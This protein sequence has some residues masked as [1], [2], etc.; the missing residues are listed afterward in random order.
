MKHDHDHAHVGHEGHAHTPVLVAPAVARADTCGSC[1]GDSASATPVVNEPPLAGLRYR[2]PAMDCASEESEI[3]RAVEGIAGIRSL[4]FRFS[5]RSLRID[6]APE[7]AELAAERIRRTGFEILPWPQ[8]PSPS[9]AAGGDPDHAPGTGIPRLILALGLATG[10]EVLSFMAPDTLLFKFM[11]MAIAGSAI[12]FAGLDVFKKG[13]SALLHGR[14][15]INA[16]MTVAVAGA[17]V[18]GQW[19]EAAM[20]MAL[21]AIAELIEAKAVDRAR[22][23]IS[24]LMAM[25][26]EEASV[27]RPDG[28]W[29]AMPVASVAVGAIARIRPGERVPLD[30]V[31]TEG[32]S[33]IDQAPVTG[34]GLL[35]DAGSISVL[36]FEK[37]VPAIRTWNWRPD[38]PAYPMEG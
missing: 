1:C 6:A 14:L 10:A 16:L 12:A 30:G 25:A 17:F 4:S 32:T 3:R 2:V 13:L 20:V 5:E 19:P 36:E 18:I 7:V 15:N 23:A 34:A 27:R 33:A 37:D 22:H 38:A 8:T 11:G 29:Q 24:G 28:S 35:L 26:P 9:A 21:Y 31:V